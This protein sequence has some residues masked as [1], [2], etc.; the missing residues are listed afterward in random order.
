MCVCEWVNEA[1]CKIKLEYLYKVEMCIYVPINLIIN[2]HCAITFEA[3]VF[4]TKSS[5][6][7]PL[8]EDLLHLIV[9]FRLSR[10]R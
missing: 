10:A 2:R 7:S 8:F 4:G 3:L 5:F 6:Y 1:S 9:E